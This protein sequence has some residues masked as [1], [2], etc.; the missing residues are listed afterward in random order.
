MRG[1]TDTAEILSKAAI[2]AEKIY[3]FT[4]GKSIQGKIEVYNSAGQL[5]RTLAE[6]FL[7][8]GINTISWNGKNDAGLS[9]RRGI[10][11][12]VVRGD[13]A[14]VSQEVIKY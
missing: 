9:L 5:V 10:Y 14:I 4:L 7:P 1:L 13:K 3:R 8:T 6:K 2:A 12:L 11:I